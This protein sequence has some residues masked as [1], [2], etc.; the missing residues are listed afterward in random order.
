[1]TTGST[2]RLQI[3]QHIRHTPYDINMDRPTKG[4][5]RLAGR[6]FPEVVSKSV[7]IDIATLD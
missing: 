4:T 7:V 1:M 2:V 5:F 3:E 6:E